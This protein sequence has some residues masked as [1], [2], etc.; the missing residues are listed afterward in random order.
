MLCS[1]CASN[2]DVYLQAPEAD[3]LEAA[4]VSVLHIHLTQPNGDI[5]VLVC[6][7]YSVLLCNVCCVHAHTV[8]PCVL[9][10]QHLSLCVWY[11]INKRL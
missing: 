4:V 6:V 2:A 7:V 5:L 8:L 11:S 1:V 10:L 9:V 3:Y